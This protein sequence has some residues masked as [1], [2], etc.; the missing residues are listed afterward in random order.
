MS[1][2]VHGGADRNGDVA[3][4]DDLEQLGVAY[5]WSDRTRPRQIYVRSHGLSAAGQ[6]RPVGT[7]SG[8]AALNGMGPAVPAIRSRITQ[9][10]SAVEAKRLIPGSKCIRE[11]ASLPDLVSRSRQ[12]K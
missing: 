10:R 8:K 6:F 7:S 1:S 5:A 2:T 3:L 4:A 9:K 12:R 11:S